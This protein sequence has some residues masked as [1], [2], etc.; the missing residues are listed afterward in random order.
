MMLKNDNSYLLRNMHHNTER[1][2]VLRYFFSV[3]KYIRSNLTV[4][5]GVIVNIYMYVKFS[6]NTNFKI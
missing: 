1:R 5:P 2:K 3:Q 4:I 6:G